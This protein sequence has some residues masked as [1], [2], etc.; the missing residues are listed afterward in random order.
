MATTFPVLG[1]ASPAVAGSEAQLIGTHSVLP[2]KYVLVSSVTIANR[3]A[4]TA[5]YYYIRVAVNDSTAED[6]QYVAHK[7]TIAPASQVTLKLG[8]TLSKDD[9]VYVKSE[10]A[11]C[12]FNAFGSLVEY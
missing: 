1:Q 3:S 10:N 12:S 11:T 7:V 2:Y 4:T 9:T 5:D 6:K 8:M